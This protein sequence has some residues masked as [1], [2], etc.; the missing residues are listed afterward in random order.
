MSA[1]DWVMWEARAAAGQAEAL[2]AWVL[3]RAPDGAQVYRSEDRV[4]LIARQIKEVSRE[5]EPL[6]EPPPALVARPAHAW[7]F[8]R[9]R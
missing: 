3:Q 2:L 8:E 1:L 5:T 7:H 6:P 9:V 4:V